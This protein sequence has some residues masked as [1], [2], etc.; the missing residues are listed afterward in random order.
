MNLSVQRTKSRPIF[1]HVS[2]VANRQ[3][4]NHNII[5]TLPAVYALAIIQNNCLP[6]R[7]AQS[8][9]CMQRFKVAK[10]SR[11]PARVE[12][13]NRRTIHA[14]IVHVRPLVPPGPNR[15]GEARRASVR[16]RVVVLPF[17]LLNCFNKMEIA[18]LF[19]LASLHLK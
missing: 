6:N 18:Q 11:A 16:A 17:S 5:E 19:K 9:P 12:A 8:P 4:I 10:E 14:H 2:H 7:P 3:A 1:I 15:T 13:G